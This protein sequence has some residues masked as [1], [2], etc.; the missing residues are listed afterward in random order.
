VTYQGGLTIAQALGRAASRLVGDV[1]EARRDAEVL[2]GHALQ[3]SRVELYAY[4]DRRLSDVDA[5]RFETLLARRQAKPVAYIVGQR[6]SGRF[7]RVPRRPH[8]RLTA[9]AG[10][11]G[12]PA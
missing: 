8:S 4:G 11:A 10:M 2:L 3:M 1:E 6:D 12:H 9:T 5:Q 7:L